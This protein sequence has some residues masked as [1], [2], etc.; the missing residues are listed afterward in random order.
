MHDFFFSGLVN[1]EKL[2]KVEEGRLA[3]STALLRNRREKPPD[4]IVLS[5]EKR[6]DVGCISNGNRVFHGRSPGGHL[7]RGRVP[8]Y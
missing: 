5:L 3:L 2:P 4:L 6:D 8:P 7:P 1:G